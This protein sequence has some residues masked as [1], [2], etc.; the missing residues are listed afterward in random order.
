MEVLS[1][2]AVMGIDTSKYESGLNKATGQA[3]NF[4]SK[5]GTIL[6]GVAIG[7]ALF[8]VGKG[9]V[10]AYKDY[11]QLVGGIDT[12]FK[13]SSAKVQAYAQEAFQNAGMSANEYMSTAI[14][15]SS[16]L[17]N[18]LGGDTEKA[19]EQTNKAITDMSD[20]ANKMGTSLEMVQNAYRGFA[21]GNFT[22]NLMSA[23]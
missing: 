16:S 3:Q 10:D 4:A 7:K 20:N 5:L 19:A 12:L 22:I 21:R 15:F 23:A 11:E 2:M 17:I 14:S 13:S 8:D 9:A 1:L 18:S 6:K